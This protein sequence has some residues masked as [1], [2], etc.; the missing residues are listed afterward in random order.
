ML[1]RQLKGILNYCHTKMPMGVV[2][3]VNANIKSCYAAGGAIAA[4][5]AICC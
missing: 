3:A 2:E 4:A 5:Y 1:L